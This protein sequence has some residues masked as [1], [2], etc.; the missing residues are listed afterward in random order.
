MM[1]RFAV[2]SRLGVT[3]LLI[4]CFLLSACARFGRHE[5]A[6]ADKVAY[7]IIQQKEEVALGEAK[8]FTLEPT[9]DPAAHA[10]FERAARYPDWNIDTYTTPSYLVNLA[11]T[12]AIAYT[13]SRD[14]QTRKEQL[15]SSALG[16]SSTRWEYGPI[17]SASATGELTRTDSGIKSDPN[18]GVERFGSG[19]LSAGV[20]KS[21]AT[22]AEVSLRFT[23]SFIHY[24]TGD[25]R[26]SSTNAASL[27]VVQPLLNGAGPLV[28]REGLRQ[29]ERDMIYAVRDFQRFQ[30]SFTI[31]IASSYY[32]LLQQLDRLDNEHQNYRNAI[33]DYEKALML[34]EAGRLARLDVD[35]TS[36]RLLSA[37]NRWNNAQTDYL[38]SLDEFKLDLGIPIDLDIGPDPNELQALRERGFV[39][40]ELDLNSAV[41]SALINRLDLKTV[42][43][44][45]SDSARAVKIAIRDFLPNLDARYEYNT[46][47][48]V[49]NDTDF[50][51]KLRRNSNTIG[52]DLALPLD[53]TPRRNRYRRALINYQQAQRRLEETRDSIIIEVRDAWRQLER[54]RKN[55]EIQLVSLQLAER[56]VDSAKLL[57]ESGEATARDLLDAQDALLASRNAL[58]DSLVTYTIQRLDFWNSIERL[59]IDPRGMWYE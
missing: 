3:S 26:E 43:D 54:T 24:I 47:T 9:E 6:K 11:D 55:Y 49:N 33:L 12:L 41:D 46:S 30:Q 32:G 53:W 22:G 5:K 16:L 35:Q 1:G 40:P 42:E 56:R 37:E 20:R 15:F 48:D 59:N 52:L 58:T 51:L 4:F 34:N 45:T 44:R 23:K 14:Y 7:A 18:S 29:A 50:S 36:Q 25:P 19:S 8:P 28:A 21:L 17:F 31:R 57:L 10:L 27:S 38:S 13:Q 2:A 39:L